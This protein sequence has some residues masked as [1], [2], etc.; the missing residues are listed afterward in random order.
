MQFPPEFLNPLTFTLKELLLKWARWI[1]PHCGVLE[2]SNAFALRH[3]RKLEVA[4]LV[5]GTVNAVKI[6]YQMRLIHQRG[7]EESC[8]DASSKLGL[9]V[10]SR[11]VPVAF[12]SGI[13]FFLNLIILRATVTFVKNNIILLY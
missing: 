12:F 6:L 8:I 13:S 2:S 9:H 1:C 7:F 5:G 11:I 3:I 4:K 10:A